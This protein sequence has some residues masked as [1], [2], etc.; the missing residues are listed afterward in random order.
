MMQ[1]FPGLYELIINFG[2]SVSAGGL[3]GIIT[4]FIVVALIIPFIP[5]KFITLARIVAILTLG[6]GFYFIFM[7]PQTIPSYLNN[8]FVYDNFSKFFMIL[9]FTIGILISLAT[10][11]TKK[12]LFY[13]LLLLATVGMIILTSTMDLLILFIG[14]EIMSVSSYGMATLKGTDKCCEAAAKYFL[15][16]AFASAITL[17]SISL[18]FINVGST[19]LVDIKNYLLATQQPDLVGILVA[20]YF[21]VGFGYKMGIVPFHMWIPDAYEGVVSNISALLAGDTKKAGVAALLRVLFAIIIPLQI[22]NW[23]LLL[24]LLSTATMIVGNVIALYQNSI[25]R[26]LAYSSIAQIGYILVGFSSMNLTGITGVILHSLTHA[27]MVTAAFTTVLIFKRVVNSDLISDYAGLGKQYPIVTLALAI[28]LF[29]L[30]GVPPLAGFISKF[31]LFTSAIEANMLWL[32]ILG[33]LNSAFSVGYYLRVIKVMYL[34]DAQN[35]MNTKA[36]LDKWQLL[37]LLI[38]TSL[39]VLIGIFPQYFISLAQNAAENII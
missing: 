25:K 30:A 23:S 38:A 20:V 3:L 7:T 24:A 21:I 10:T 36:K 34:D 6:S 16:G 11:N 9:F 19:N 12:P 29:S 28:N 13:S 14:W 33:V 1:L 35:E 17:Y 22:V 32:A 15:Y 37:T 18:I 4:T 31:I 8:I 2:N 5:R 39:V 26:M 27:L